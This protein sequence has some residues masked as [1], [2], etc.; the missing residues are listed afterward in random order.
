MTGSNRTG[1]RK[2]TA[3]RARKSSRLGGRSPRRAARRGME[4]S[5]S[6]AV[7]AAPGAVAILDA[8]GKLIHAN[9]RA[10]E[11]L[12]LGVSLSQGGTSADGRDEPGAPEATQ[13]SFEITRF[14]LASSDTG[15]QLLL[16]EPG[17]PFGAAFEPVG[18]DDRVV[19][20][21]YLASG[22]AHALQA[23]LGLMETIAEGLDATLAAD[24]WEVRRSLGHLRR[25][26]MRSHALVDQL[27]HH[28][29]RQ[30]LAP[31]ALQ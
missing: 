20:L 25:C 4:A 29:A 23:R 15:W 28:P 2:R 22:I 26:L 21:G 16:L 27:L 11:I 18:V 3:L 8:S 17:S 10:R 7:D 5:L 24:D 1:I 14:P 13:A 6:R 9:A 30:S 19:K 31:L 12:D